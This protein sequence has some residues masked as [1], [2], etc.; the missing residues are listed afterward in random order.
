M[1]KIIVEN[2][3]NKTIRAV[4]N[5]TVLDN[6]HENYMDW[7]HACGKKGNCT[8]CKMIV[9]KGDENL[10]PFS[11]PEERFI[12]I[13]RLKDHERLACQCKLFFVADV[14]DL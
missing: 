11:Q 4:S 1:P 7:M 9:L 5:L 8:T 10:T 2:L 12:A 13:G 14:E 6:I 3:F